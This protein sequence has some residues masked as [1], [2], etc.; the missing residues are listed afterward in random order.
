MLQWVFQFHSISQLLKCQLLGKVVLFNI[1]RL[2]AQAF[3]NSKLDLKNYLGRF[4]IPHQCK[5]LFQDSLF[6]LAELKTSPRWWQ[7][8]LTQ[9]SSPLG[10][11]QQLPCHQQ[12]HQHCFDYEKATLQE[13]GR[14]VRLPQMSLWLSNTQQGQHSLSQISGQGFVIYCSDHSTHKHQAAPKMLT[15]HCKSVPHQKLEAHK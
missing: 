6:P 13:P 4:N 15:R 14:P 11:A 9:P 8:Y 5:F 1:E 3:S 7:R 12:C 10:M 2:S